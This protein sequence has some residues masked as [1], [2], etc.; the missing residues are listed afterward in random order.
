M[1]ETQA[2]LPHLPDKRFAHDRNRTEAPGF[3]GERILKPSEDEAAA[4]FV[5]TM[6]VV[7]LGDRLP[8]TAGRILAMLILRDSPVGLDEIADY[9]R[10]SRSGVSTNTRDLE[11]MGVIKRTTKSGDRQYYFS[12]VDDAV[13]PLLNSHVERMGSALE[14][15]SKASNTLPR[16]WACAH[17]RLDR[18]GTVYS[19]AIEKTKA[20][21]HEVAERD[22]K[23]SAKNM[24]HSANGERRLSA[25]RST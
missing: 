10:V 19:I 1:H 17:K 14:A 21:L 8:R 11:R 5:E 24:S 9:L 25:Q 20:L 13:S 4:E 18:M 22:G 6:G 12:I 15:I 23:P 16:K 7:F 3:E 2:R